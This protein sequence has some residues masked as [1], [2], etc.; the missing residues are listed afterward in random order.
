MSPLAVQLYSV[1]EEAA[2]GRPAVLRAIAE[3][4]YG[5]VEPYDAHLDPE[6]LRDELAE[7]GLTVC[8]VHAPLL[9]EG[10]AAALAAAVTVGADTVIVP[11]APGEWF[12]DREGVELAAARIGEAAREAA[13]HGLRL[14]YHNHWWEL[15][16]RVDG[17][18]ALEVL[19]DL[20]D[21]S[22]LLEVDLY[23]AATGGVDPAELLTRLGARVS[24]LHVKD[25]PATRE[26]PMTA[27]GAGRVPVV[28][29]LK[30]APDAV[31]IVE[32]DHCAGDM[33]RA[34]ADSHAYLTD[35]VASGRVSR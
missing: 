17:R 11:A 2:T 34:L 25:G 20:L 28:E 16:Q 9:D 19:A 29:A 30:A 12:A 35:L 15:E 21:P 6:G 13:D 7:A 32:L 18:P 24:H 8:S 33:L 31:R 14:G 26:G 10:R 3:M 22:V 4:G 5:A 23:W 27:V 1:R